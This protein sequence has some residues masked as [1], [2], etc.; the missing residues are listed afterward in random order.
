MPDFGTFLFLAILFF[1]FQSWMSAE[2]KA[3]DDSPIGKHVRSNQ[4]CML[5]VGGFFIL[6]SAAAAACFS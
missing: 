4:G 3:L 6:A 2:K 1:A 5:V